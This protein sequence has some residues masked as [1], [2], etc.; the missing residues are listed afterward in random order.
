MKEWYAGLAQR[1]K[2]IVTVGAALV[3]LLLIYALLWDPLASRATSL[4]QSV[5]EQS[6]L[7]AWM[8]D[9]AA[10]AQRLRA[11]GGGTGVNGGRSMLSVVD[12][13]AK[14]AK[15]MGA[16]KRIQPE[17]AELVRVT[18]EQAAFDDLMLWLGTLQRSYAIDVA[19]LSI[20]RLDA[21][22]VSARLALRRSG[23]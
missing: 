2:L 19:D 18:L 4:Q 20:D 6:A 14:S 22:R 15:L 13:T 21:G 9:A 7:H 12:Q 3:A 5:T 8:Q 17:G 23:T 1:E 10:E 11:V 16:V